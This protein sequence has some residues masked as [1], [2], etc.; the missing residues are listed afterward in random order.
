MLPLNRL[1][2]RSRIQLGFA[3]SAILAVSLVAL[4]F[5][6]LHAL[7]S[8]FRRLSSFGADM[9]RS[10]SVAQEIVRLQNAAELYMHDGQLSARRAVDYRYARAERELAALRKSPTPV[11][12]TRLPTIEHHLQT[13]YEV[14]GEA[15]RQREARTRLA[16]SGIRELAGATQQAI[17]AILV[18]DP[19]TP[20]ARLLADANIPYTLLQIE[21]NA[22]RYF[23]KLDGS[24]MREARRL[25]ES[26]KQ[27]MTAAT[28]A[29]EATPQATP[30]AQAHEAANAY[31]AAIIEAEQ[32]TRGYYFLSNVVLA[33]EAYEMLYQARQLVETVETR[34]AEIDSEANREISHSIRLTVG[35]S[36]VLL[37]IM[38]G[39][40][41]LIARS[42]ALP[43]SELALTFRA[44]A[45]GKPDTQI[46]PQPMGGE[47]GELAYAAEVF[48]QKNAET[49]Q[50]L[51]RA[52]E[53]GEQLEARVAERTRELR[54][55]NGQLQQLSDTD[56]LTGLYNRRYFDKVL[57][58]DWSRTVRQH[59]P[60]AAMMLDVDHFKAYNDHYGHPAG[61]RC[62]QQLSQLLRSLLRRDTDLV[63]RY[64]GE[65]FVI[66]LPD[67]A[68]APALELAE[69]IR[70]A[71][72]AIGIKHQ[73]SETGEVTVS[74]GLACYHPGGIIEDTDSLMHY[75]DLALYQSKADGRNRVSVFKAAPAS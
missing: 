19:D 56:G 47:L 1:R 32:R 21:R 68:E 48:R 22:Y 71:V 24:D 65:E 70:R 61:D 75:A 11:I 20:V 33:G 27:T 3:V 37:L 59:E 14:F 40:S 13:F 31:A 43:V 36:I 45:S 51:E 38:L 4:S 8:D 62:L 58:R 15:Q 44:L 25:I 42:I 55:A 67:T 74:V 16:E 73:A 52:R 53:Q 66:L 18:D 50:L 9:Q 28:A 63:A 69:Q 64:G 17:E 29:A 39:L 7:Y 23:D 10:L 35:M 12:A 54:I 41:Y 2:L 60:L 30:I 5:S 49:E 6:N 57:A 34:M 26:L 72:Q 46:Q